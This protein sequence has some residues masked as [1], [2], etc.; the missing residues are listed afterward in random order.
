MK[1]GD[2]VI[3]ADPDAGDFAGKP[4]PAVIIQADAFLE[5]HASI[6]TCLISGHLTGLALFRL[7]V[8]AD[9]HTGLRKPSEICIDKVQTVWR[10]RTGPRIGCVSDEIM[11]AVDQ[12]LRRWV[13]L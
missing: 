7:P 9:E 6:T 2:I 4:R 5:D 11:F 8:P 3:I 10:H 1:R 13:A 12:A